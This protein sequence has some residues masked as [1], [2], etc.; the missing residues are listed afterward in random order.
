MAFLSVFSQ[1]MGSKAPLITALPLPLHALL[2]ESYWSARMVNV[3]LIVLASWALFRLGTLLAGRRVALLAVILLNT[4]P[5][6]AAMSRQFLV[7]YGLIT[8]VIVWVYYLAQWQRGEHRW[9]PGL[10]V[11][12]WASDC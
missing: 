1:V 9:T 3:L 4:F 11:S 8:L 2:G 5:L 7:E 10:S 12:F 6:A